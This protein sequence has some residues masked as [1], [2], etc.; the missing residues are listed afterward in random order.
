[1]K[2]ILLQELKGKG[3]EGDVIDVAAGFANNY[4]LTQG[5][6]VK[7]TKGNLKQLEQRRHNIAKREETRL[8]DAAKMQEALEKTSIKVI[9][10]VGD[11]GQLFGSVTAQMIA[12]ACKEQAGL[13]VDRRHIELGKPIKTAG[14]HEVVVSIYRDIKGTVKVNVVGENDA[15]EAEAEAE[16]AAAAEE[17]AEAVAEEAVEAEAVAASADEPEAEAAAE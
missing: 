5:I 6:A 7:A 11:E 14:E 12:D 9:A 17:A 15:E 2:V 4:L 1:M 13:E 8:A 3:G 10:Q 16:E